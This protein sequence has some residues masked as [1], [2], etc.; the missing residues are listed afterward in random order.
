MVKHNHSSFV[1][2]YFF[3]ISFFF[4]PLEKMGREREVFQNCGMTIQAEARQKNRKWLHSALVEWILV[5]NKSD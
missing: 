1:E 5:K 2:L 4:F 3:F